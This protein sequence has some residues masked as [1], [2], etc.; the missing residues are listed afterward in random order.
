MVFTSRWQTFFRVMDEFDALWALGPVK[1]SWRRFG[2]WEWVWLSIQDRCVW[3]VW[4]HV[5]WTLRII[6]QPIDL[7]CALIL[8]NWPPLA[9]CV[10]KHQQMS[11]LENIQDHAKDGNRFQIFS[12]W[13]K[14]QVFWMLS[15]FQHR[16]V[17]VPPCSYRPNC[18]WHWW[19]KIT[20]LLD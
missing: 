15:T 19:S 4:G 13:N 1:V 14:C 10:W 12:I 6:Y 20:L 17:L 2:G 16:Q 8:S 7:L 9:A 11:T 18:Y 3:Q 5:V